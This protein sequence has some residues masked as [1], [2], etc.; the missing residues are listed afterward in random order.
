MFFPRNWSI[1]TVVFT[2][3]IIY[4]FDFITTVIVSTDLSI[5]YVVKT[6]LYVPRKQQTF[7]AYFVDYWQSWRK[8]QLSSFASYFFYV[9]HIRML[10]LLGLSSSEVALESTLRWWCLWRLC[11]LSPGTCT[12]TKTLCARCPG[13][14]KAAWV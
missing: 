4:N 1:E 13:P 8:T 10:Y 7:N 2:F 5:F 12:P 9:M 6:K 3:T 11:L 14:A